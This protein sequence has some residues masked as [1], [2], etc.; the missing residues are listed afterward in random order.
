MRR[1]SNPMFTITPKALAIIQRVTAHRALA[2]TSG[3]RIAVRDEP[4]ASLQVKAVRGPHPGDKVWERDDARLY[5][6]PGADR[7]VEAGQLDAVRTS[8]GR[9]QFVLKAAA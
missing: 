4:S 6:G 1:Q 5:L 3:L 2:P 9:V 7:R 8:D